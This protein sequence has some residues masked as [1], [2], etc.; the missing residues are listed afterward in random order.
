[1]NTTNS[2]NHI[3]ARTGSNMTRT[4][5]FTDKK[6]EAESFSDKL[7]DVFTSGAD[8]TDH[9]TW[10]EAAQFDKKQAKD[11]F[12]FAEVSGMGKLAATGNVVLNTVT[13]PLA[14]TA[15][16]AVAAALAAGPIFS[17]GLVAGGIG[18]G[19]KCLV[20]VL[21]E[22]MPAAGSGIVSLSHL[23]TQNETDG[24]IDGGQKGAAAPS[25]DLGYL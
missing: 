5:G 14:M 24:S 9:F 22:I 11:G 13:N 6:P 21:S 7:T 23:L 17:V 20:N 19:A 15:F 16:G 1:M 3:L 10:R 8:V 12:Q 25:Q 2:L 18:L 4:F